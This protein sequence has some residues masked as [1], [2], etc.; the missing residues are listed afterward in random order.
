M[1][2]HV[3]YVKVVVHG[4]MFTIRNIEIIL[5]HFPPPLMCAI[6]LQGHLTLG[7]DS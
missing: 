3:L 7:S 2:Q 5:L 4:E 1:L 6:H